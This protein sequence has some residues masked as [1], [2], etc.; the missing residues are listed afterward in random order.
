MHLK[1]ERP[2]R[3]RRDEQNEN[4]LVLI[5]KE[6]KISWHKK[7]NTQD[8]RNKSFAQGRVLTLCCLVCWSCWLQRRANENL[9]A[10]IEQGCDMAASAV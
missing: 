7:S 6:K 8:L 5:V 3:L 9:G 10:N 1:H 2:V 4:E